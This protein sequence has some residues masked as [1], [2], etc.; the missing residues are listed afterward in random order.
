MYAAFLQ[1]NKNILERHE[2]FETKKRVQL[3]A[4]TN[5]I[6]QKLH[7]ASIKLLVEV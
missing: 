6:H 5:F 3:S 2:K 7:V 1:K 4:T